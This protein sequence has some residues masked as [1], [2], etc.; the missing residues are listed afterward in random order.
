MFNLRVP[1]PERNE[2]FL[3]N[4]LT[5]AQLVV[6]PDVAALLDRSSDSR[7]TIDLRTASAPTRATRFELLTDNGFL[8]ADRAGRSARRSTAIFDRV[9]SSTAELNIT[10]LTTLQC[11]FAC[12]YCFQGDHGDYNKFADKM[13]LETAER[14][15]DWIE[16]ELDRVHPEKFTLTFFGG[17]PL[18]NLPV[19]YYLAERLW[20]ATAGARRRDDHHASSP[21]ACC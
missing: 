5:D 7:A 1:L 6:S 17:E 13:S 11:N 19:M 3:M 4:T 9:T 10:V 21:T 2:V 16:R 18:L 8:V 20:H 12:D 15:G 14:V